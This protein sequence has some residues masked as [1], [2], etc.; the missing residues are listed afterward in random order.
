M[1]S[2]KRSMDKKIDAA[3]VV[4]FLKKNKTR[5]NSVVKKKR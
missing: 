4:C 3:R 1:S 5:Q 2:V